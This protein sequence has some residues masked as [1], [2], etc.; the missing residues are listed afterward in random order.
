MRKKPELIRRNEALV[1]TQ[2]RFAGKPFRL[3]END[4]VKLARF[5]LRMMG[6]RKLPSTGHYSTAAGA[7]RALRKTGHS[8]LAALMDALLEPIAPAMA[9]A[10]D[11]VMP[12][13]DPEAEAAEIGTVMVMVGAGKY[14]GWHPE[15]DRLAVMSLLAIEKAWRA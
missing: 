9:L 14:L 4:C 2:A 5:H 11:L 13:S 12:P 15:H 10:G 8:T 6:H 1:K 7:V 3:G